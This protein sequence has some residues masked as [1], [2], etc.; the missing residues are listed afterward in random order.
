MGAPSGLRRRLAATG[1]RVGE[2]YRAAVTRGRWAWVVA[3]VALATVLTVV[4]PSHAG[5]GGG[6]GDLLPTDSKVLQVE[7][8]VLDEFR[9]PVLS[10]TTVVVHRDGGLSLL[11]RA[12]SL[13]WALATTQR[14]IRDPGDAEPGTVAAAIPVPTGTA[15]TTVTYLYVSDGTG[16][17][18]TV[19][20]ANVNASHF[21]NQAGVQTY[22]TG[23]VPAQVAQS[24]YLRG[25]L[26]IFELASVLLI[27]LVVALAFRSL[28]APLAV[29]AIAAVGYLVYVPLLALTADLLGFEVPSQLEPVLLAL[30]LGVVTDYCVLF[31]STFRDELAGGVD[32]ATG[33]RRALVLDGSV[34]AVAGLTVAGGT[35]SLLAA[36]FGIFRALGP[37]L[38]LTVLVGLAVCLTLTPAIMTILG[39][40]LFS[41]LPV[42]GSRPAHAT[43]PDGSEAAAVRTRRGLALLTSRRT[44]WVAAAG[45][46][47]LLSL[48]SLPLG[49]ARLDLSFTTGLPS[50]DAAAE[51]AGLLREAGLRGIT[52]PTE[53]LVRQPGLTSDRDALNALQDLVAAQPGVARVLGPADTPLPSA[54]GLVLAQSG[55]AAR[56]VVFYDTDPLAA[57][58]ISH[59]RQLSRDVPALAVRAGLP[60]AR[61]ALTGQT[62]IA[63]EVAELT[64]R[65]L[66][67]TLLTA[68]VVELLILALY[69]RALVAPL[70][71]L[72]CSG[73]SVAA[74]LGLTTFVFQDLLGGQGLTFYAPFASAVLLIALGSDYNVFS[75][76][77]IWKE[78]RHRTLADALM[79]AVPRSSRAITIAGLILAGTFALVAVIP[80]S[81]FRQIAF[82]MT[83][84]ILIDTLVVRP[85]LTPAVLTLLGRGAS[86]PSRRITTAG[87]PS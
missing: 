41:V 80:L 1:P 43:A 56:Y 36:P 70:V 15:E 61:V 18:N 74:A 19:R 64:R 52:A 82:A 10:G 32:A 44:A 16:L 17:H 20:L 83:V 53:I 60:E 4:V 68:L 21:H 26:P 13:L 2:G 62:L 71:L 50:D 49:H 63:S 37:A 84:G 65:S 38:A 40:R 30:L 22:V 29:V 7:R 42:R 28:L 5:D 27:L 73:L 24:S 85:V 66:E 35:I 12:D 87:S 86:W 6:F 47:V 57:T 46:V 59:A 31:F 48:A 75:V 81:T 58:A 9:V 77:A 67:L 76:G 33:V 39:W 54:Q 79:V 45:V 51:G 78:A 23:F 69:L 14:T 55:D 8:D 3:W 34:V 72:A 11:T 25:Y